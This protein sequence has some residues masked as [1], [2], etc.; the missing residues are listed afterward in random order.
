[1]RSALGKTN[2]PVGKMI[3]L[4]TVDDEAYHITCVTNAL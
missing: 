1:M 4:N 2:T 3:L